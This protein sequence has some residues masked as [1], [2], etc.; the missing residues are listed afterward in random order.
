MKPTFGSGGSPERW[1]A[2][3]ARGFPRNIAAA[4]Q[5]SWPF[6]VGRGPVSGPFL[7]DLANDEW[8]LAVGQ[9]GRRRAT[10][11]ASGPSSAASTNLR[12]RAKRVGGSAVRIIRFAVL[13]PFGDEAG[14]Q[15]VADG[16]G[17]Q[18]D[19][20]AIPRTVVSTRYTLVKAVRKSVEKSSPP[21]VRFA[22]CSPSS[23]LPR[24]SPPAVCTD[25][26][27]APV[28]QSRPSARVPVNA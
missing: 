8:A 13:W 7:H 23:N 4:R 18:R 27:P 26:P 12:H 3:A 17:L 6:E 19:P 10:F 2:A 5:A 14:R 20:G 15:W 11:N 21:N 28:V 1:P 25:T 16:R 22:A 24:Q 9:F